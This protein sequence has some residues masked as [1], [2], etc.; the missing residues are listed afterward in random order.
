VESNWDDVDPMP[1][2]YHTDGDR[3][4]T[5][6]VKATMVSAKGAKDLLLPMEIFLLPLL[7]PVSLTTQKTRYKLM[8]YKRSHNIGN[9]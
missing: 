7:F 6:D 1:G 2:V 4:S 8:I 9:I 3:P 5:G